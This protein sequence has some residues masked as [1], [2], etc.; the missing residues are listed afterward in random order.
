MHDKYERALG[1]DNGEPAKSRMTRK[2]SPT[3]QK[4]LAEIIRNGGEAHTDG[5]CY[6]RSKPA[7]YGTR[8]RYKSEGGSSNDYY[9]VETSTINGLVARGCLELLVEIKSPASPAYQATAKAR[10]ICV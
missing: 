4:A 5:G 6:W 1:A 3:M 8:L 2:L 10:D 9:V 7:P